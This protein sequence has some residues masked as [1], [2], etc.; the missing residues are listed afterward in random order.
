MLWRILRGIPLA[1]VLAGSLTAAE[2][3]ES[4]YDHRNAALLKPTVHNL[5]FTSESVH[6]FPVP[7]DNAVGTNDLG[8]RPS[9]PSS[10][11]SIDSRP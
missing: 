3:I 10:I 4:L 7:Q 2:K 11:R 8:A 1:C 9:N 5:L 6:L